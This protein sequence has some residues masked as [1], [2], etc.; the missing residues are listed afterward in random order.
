MATL[1][2]NVL[3][4]QDWAS[5]I[6]PDGS[7]AVVAEILAQV[8]PILQ[9]MGWKEGNLPTGH[10]HTIRAGLPAGAWRLLNYGVANE[11]SKT[12]QVT[13][14]TGMLE[15][16]AETDKKLA[17]LNGNE[18]EFRKSE[19]VAF[20]EGLS[21]TLASTVFYG[22]TQV[23]PEK[24]LGLS[25]RY[26]DLSAPNAVN[27]I[28][29]GGS[30]ADNAS[31]WLC[32]WGERTGFGI[33]PKGSKAGLEIED[34]GQK[35][36]SD[37]AGGQYEG[38]RTHFAWEAGLSVRDW[39]AFARLCNIDVSDLTDDAATGADLI[40]NMIKLTHKVDPTKV[41][42]KRVFYVS[43][44]VYLFLDLQTFNNAQMNV[45][46]SDSPHGERV[47]MFR[48]IPVKKVDALLETEAVVS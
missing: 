42:G 14:T 7:I 17:K 31:V 10:K 39:R 16:Y 4:L 34:L 24:F 25:A 44:T 21:Q 1:G 8:N 22:N 46:Y 48:G 43:E 26:N 20:V 15:S 13:D 33:F 3:T 5:R 37:G 18:K 27:I 40:T 41:M 12:V 6:D 47:M 11:K 9:D 28:S 36:L 35:T 29:A 2:T 19:D 30:G 38:Y 32:A 45:K 23:D